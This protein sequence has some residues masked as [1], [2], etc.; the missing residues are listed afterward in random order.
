[1]STIEPNDPAVDETVRAVLRA[2]HAGRSVPSFDETWAAAERQLRSRPVRP[3]SAARPRWRSLGYAT[4]A[5]ATVVIAVAL[6]RFAGDRPEAPAEAWPATEITAFDRPRQ[7]ASSAWTGADD[8]RTER[9]IWYAPTD[10]LL[11]I[12]A[13]RYGAQP[14]SL[15]YY[16]PI[17]LEVRQ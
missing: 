12:P 8:P 9:L 3:R 14:A 17:H 13:L 2:E 10:E 11:Q 16:D 7:S 6:N 5:T 15:T 4:V 1:M